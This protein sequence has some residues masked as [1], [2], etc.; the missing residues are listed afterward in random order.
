MNN[1][2]A[3]NGALFKAFE[4]LLGIVI[5]FIAFHL[6][7]GSG[8][9][10]GL[11]SLIIGLLTTIVTVLV[12]EFS[13]QMEKLENINS[14]LSNVLIIIST[15]QSEKFKS[16][17]KYG[18]SE[19]PKEDIPITWFELLWATRKTYYATN[20]IRQEDIY[21]FKYA[22]SALSIQKAQ[23]DVRNIIVNKVFILDSEDEID[24]I[25]ASLIDQTN[26]GINAKFILKETIDSTDFLKN[27]V[28]K[29]ETIDFGIFDSSV[30]FLWQLENNRK[31]KSGKL[32]FNEKKINEYQLFF[33][34][35][36]REARPLNMIRRNIQC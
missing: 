11:F 31:I 8:L 1:L 30:A 35:L 7:K 33:N 26:L 34:I 27:R 12:I 15:D 10:E 21:E 18:F 13:R 2:N 6:S 25:E 29:L 3:T 22:E 14:N 36:Y 17:L 9:P 4:I 24:K 19:I 28:E 16:V 5:G 32:I 23:I 20:Y